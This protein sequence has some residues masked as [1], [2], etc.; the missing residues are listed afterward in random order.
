MRKSPEVSTEN[1]WFTGALKNLKNRILWNNED[2]E[3]E[4]NERLKEICAD[5]T[6]ELE[7]VWSEDSDR[8]A[9]RNIKLNIIWS[10]TFEI[11]SYWMKTVFDW[12][13]L[14]D[15]IDWSRMEIIKIDKDLYNK[16]WYFERN[17]ENEKVI[18]GIIKT[19][20]LVNRLKSED[21]SRKIAFDEEEWW[22]YA[23]WMFWILND[24][25]LVKTET[26]QWLADS[27][28]V[29]VYRYAASICKHLNKV[30]KLQ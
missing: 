14:Y 10:N 15:I 18:K 1:W 4:N 9:K 3:A 5:A 20:N 21:Y 25:T 16:S 23:S 6:K 19:M 12:N 26:L 8:R 27:I 11:E 7:G 29:D 24:S 28:W 17:S 30:K 22:I 2:L 13:F